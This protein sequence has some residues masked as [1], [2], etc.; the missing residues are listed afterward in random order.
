MVTPPFPQI[1]GVCLLHSSHM[2]CVLYRGSCTNHCATLLLSII[3]PQQTICPSSYKYGCCFDGKEALDPYKSNCRSTY[4]Y[5]Y[6]FRII[7]RGVDQ[8]EMPSPLASWWPV[9]LYFRKEIS[10]KKTRTTMGERRVNILT[11]YVFIQPF[12]K[13]CISLSF[14]SRLLPLWGQ[15]YGINRESKDKDYNVIWLQ[16]FSIASRLSEMFRDLMFSF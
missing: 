2:V 5:V 6:L 4:I 13:F 9:F 8:Q 14:C 15:S 10:S 12:H 7:I 11:A 1:I 16:R 3:A